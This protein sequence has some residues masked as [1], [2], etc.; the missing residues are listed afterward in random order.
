MKSSAVSTLCHRHL[1]LH[2]DPQFPIEKLSNIISSIVSRANINWCW[3]SLLSL[4]CYHN[5]ATFELISC[6]K[7][8]SLLSKR[9]LPVKTPCKPQDSKE[10]KRITLWLKRTFIWNCLFCS[11]CVELTTAEEWSISCL[12]DFEESTH[13]IKYCCN[14]FKQIINRYAHSRFRLLCFSVQNPKNLNSSPPTVWQHT[15]RNVR[16]NALLSLLWWWSAWW[17]I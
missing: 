3:R 10:F 13:K 9:T 15:N 6:C 7:S 4:H 5:L 11:L 12:L 14:E 2:L 17:C 16:L 1:F 8:I